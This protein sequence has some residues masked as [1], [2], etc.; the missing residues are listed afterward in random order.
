M[1]LSKSNT[2]K[3]EV[4]GKKKAKAKKKV[5]ALDKIKKELAKLENLHEKEEAIIENIND[6]IED[7]ED[8]DS[9]WL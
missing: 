5:S 7:E 1:K 8:D 4:M 6:I 2:S 3:E 9:G